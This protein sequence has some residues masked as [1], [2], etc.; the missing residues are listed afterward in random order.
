MALDPID[1]PGAPPTPF[2]L[3]SYDNE[4]T[5]EAERLE[6]LAERKAQD[7]RDSNQRS[8]NY[9][10]TTVIFAAV[11]FFGGVSAKLRSRRNQLLALGFAIIVLIGTT[12]VV[13]TFP[14]EI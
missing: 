13:A 4:A 8:D 14:I 1:N 12:I 10:L 9:V 5:T 11:L 2:D 3:A 6:G 7:A